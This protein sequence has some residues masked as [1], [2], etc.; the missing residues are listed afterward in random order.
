MLFSLNHSCLA[1]FST[2]LQTKDRF[3]KI[4]V[5]FAN[6]SRISIDGF[7]KVYRR[8]LIKKKNCST[9]KLHFVDQFMHFVGVLQAEGLQNRWLHQ[10]A[11]DQFQRLPDFL[12]GSAA[13]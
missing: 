2:V 3:S 8:P 10:A 11:S 6:L 12:F 5:I 7:L 9:R 4:E 13:G 1:F